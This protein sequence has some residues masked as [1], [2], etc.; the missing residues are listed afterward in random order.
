MGRSR[1][2][3]SDLSSPSALCYTGTHVGK[4]KPSPHI[5]PTQRGSPDVVG[6]P[7][8]SVSL[9]QDSVGYNLSFLSC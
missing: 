5:L 3:K 8:Q 2:P 6:S 4:A 1:G 9:S 7:G